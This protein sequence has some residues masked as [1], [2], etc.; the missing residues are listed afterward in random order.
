MKWNFIK[1]GV[2][3]KDCELVVGISYWRD[4]EYVYSLE[5]RD[6]GKIIYCKKH[7]KRL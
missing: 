1:D 3:P 7:R 4:K 6:R 2:L 5:Y